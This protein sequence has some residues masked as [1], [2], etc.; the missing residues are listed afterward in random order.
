MAQ[1]RGRTPEWD[2]R[3]LNKATDEKGSVGA[4]WNNE[5]GSIR[6]K[7]NTCVVLSAGPDC[8]LTLFKKDPNFKGIPSGSRGKDTFPRGHKPTQEETDDRPF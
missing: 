3:F 4:A 8:I 1:V 2:L 5:D 7:L 6:I